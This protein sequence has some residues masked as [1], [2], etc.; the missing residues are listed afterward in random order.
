[1]WLCKILQLYQTLLS[2]FCRESSSTTLS[3]SHHLNLS[4]HYSLIVGQKKD[5]SLSKIRMKLPLKWYSFFNFLQF[6]QTISSS[7]FVRLRVDNNLLISLMAMVFFFLYS[8]HIFMWYVEG[9]ICFGRFKKIFGY[10]R[11]ILGV[12]RR[13]C[14][15]TL[16]NSESSNHWAGR[17]NSLNIGGTFTFES[18]L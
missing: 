16:Y 13:I 17:K 2:S 10:S 18:I 3:P 9:F 12:S 1:M 8:H 11:V 14:I 15:A 7:I 6:S 4:F 5:T